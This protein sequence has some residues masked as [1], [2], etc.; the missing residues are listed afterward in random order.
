M[1]DQ[2]PLLMRGP[3]WCGETQ[4]NCPLPT[5]D[6]QKYRSGQHQCFYVRGVPGFRHVFCVEEGAQG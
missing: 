4:R 5:T 6:L 1:I 2:S 3:S